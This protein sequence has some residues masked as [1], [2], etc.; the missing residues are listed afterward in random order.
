MLPLLGIFLV[1]AIASGAKAGWT[2][3][4]WQTPA[5]PPPVKRTS[6]LPKVPAK[7]PAR[8]VVHVKRPVHR[9]AH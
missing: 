3:P 2:V 6:P 7:K 9:K 8:H 5:T 1:L 4:G